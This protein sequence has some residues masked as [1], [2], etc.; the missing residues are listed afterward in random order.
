MRLWTGP[1]T[2][3]MVWI[4]SHAARR[5]VKDKDMTIPPAID[6]DSGTASHDMPAPM[7]DSI[8]GPILGWFTLPED[9]GPGAADRMVQALVAD[10]SP[11]M[12]LAGA[13]QINHDLGAE[14]A[15]DM[16][17]LVIGE[18]D[19]PVRISQSLG[20]GS[21]G[22]RLDAG[23][24]ELAAARV[25]A[26][27]EGADLLIVP[28]FGRQE[29]FGR[30][31]YS[32]IG[33][34]MMQEL[35]VLLY[36]PPEQRAAFT[37]F[38]GDLARE[39]AP[40]DLVQWCLGWQH[41]ATTTAQIDASGLLCPLPVLRLRK[42]LLPLPEGGRLRLI[43][44]DPAAALDVPHFCQQAGHRLI[45]TQGLENGAQAYIVER[46]PIAPDTSDRE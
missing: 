25:A 9:A 20:S 37:D 46:G 39:L 2:C 6:A 42:A 14:C 4:S 33:Q 8:P 23:A 10:L 22:C 29:A 44:T 13:V 1:E 7:S 36:V 28:K 45:A 38:S 27:L 15:C 35:P 32:V 16:D 43:A 12:R 5:R 31:F 40:T 26:R 3:R 19:R 18:E 17:V 41:G 30:G 11:V 34:A 21:S 24:L